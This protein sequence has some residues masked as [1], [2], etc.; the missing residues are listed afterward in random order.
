MLLAPSSAGAVESDS[1]PGPPPAPGPTAQARCVGAVC[2]TRPEKSPRPKPQARCFHS[3][4]AVTALRV[5]GRVA[6]VPPLEV[7][8]IFDRS[9]ESARYKLGASRAASH[10]Y[11]EQKSEKPEPS[12]M[13]A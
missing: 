1:A 6:E 7:N 4:L 5:K 12:E 3:K 9:M 13:C 8:G 10:A 11:A 2:A